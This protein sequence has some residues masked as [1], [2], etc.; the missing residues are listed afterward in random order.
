MGST[1]P[2]AVILD[3]VKRRQQA[4]HKLSASRLCCECNETSS[5]PPAPDA[6]AFLHDGLHPQTVSQNKLLPSAA[7]VRVFYHNNEE[8]KLY[9]CHMFE[10]LSNK[11][12]IYLHKI[13]LNRSFYAHFLEEEIILG[14]ISSK[15]KAD[16]WAVW[17]WG[18][19]NE[20]LYNITC[21]LCTP[22]ID[23]VLV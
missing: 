4:E 19:S 3:C 10:R 8:N 15:R 2:R 17:V 16:F 1:I 23:S 11:S 5:F 9:T 12:T 13:L 22:L 7:F 18:L 20:P 21:L 14:H 6:L